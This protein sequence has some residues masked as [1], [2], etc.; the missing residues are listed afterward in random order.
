[1]GSLPIFKLALR[2]TYW[3]VRKVFDPRGSRAS[4][5]DPVALAEA[6]RY[7]GGKLVAPGGVS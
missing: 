5:A 4:R 2:P 1:M 6:R 7:G 3:L